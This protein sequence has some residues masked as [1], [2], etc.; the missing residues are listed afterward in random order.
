MSKRDLSS[1][2]LADCVEAMICAYYLSGGLRAA[3]DFM[4]KLGVPVLQK[5]LAPRMPSAFSDPRNNAQLRYV[6]ERL[7]AFEEQMN[8]KFH[9]RK[10]LLEAFTHGS[11]VDAITPTYQRLEFIGDAVLEMLITEFIFKAFDKMEPGLFA[12]CAR[13]VMFAQET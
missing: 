8:Y 3:Q 11:F 10:L 13:R 5:E 6:W 7:P 1:A 9:D 2:V 12:F 4:R